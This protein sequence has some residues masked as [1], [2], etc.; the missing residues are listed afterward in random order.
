[1]TTAVHRKTVYERDGAICGFCQGHVGWED[2]DLDH[3]VP[4]ALG[5]KTTLTNLRVAHKRC[6]RSNGV[7][8]RTQLQTGVA[9]RLYGRLRFMIPSEL[10]DRLRDLALRE[11]RPLSTQTQILL[12][13][14]LEDEAKEVVAA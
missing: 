4:R 14:A 12:E 6:N 5:G 11:R 1:M 9:K 10:H 2:L 7:H 3:V 8:V 13:R